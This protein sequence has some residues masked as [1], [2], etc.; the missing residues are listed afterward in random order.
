M[1]D[2]D[3]AGT[4]AGRRE[5]GTDLCARIGRLEKSNARLRAGLVGGLMLV[6]GIGLG[7]L[8]GLTQDEDDRV[9][10]YTATDDTIYRVHESGRIEYLRVE[11]NPPHT[12]EG[13]FDWGK[14]KVDERYE[15]QD[16]P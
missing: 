11:D 12:T 6:V 2:S 9:V 13:V 7:G 14:V 15:L 1:N 5:Q 16:R 4:V 3:A 8:G 10:S